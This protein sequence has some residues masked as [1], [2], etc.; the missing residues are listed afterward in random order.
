MQHLLVN[1][2]LD[3]PVGVGRRVLDGGHH[4]EVVRDGPELEIHDPLQMLV[5]MRVIPDQQTPS[6]FR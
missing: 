5:Q 6:L 2:R 4:R 3:E 1:H